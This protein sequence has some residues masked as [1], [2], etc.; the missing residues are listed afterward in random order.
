[1]K[2]TVLLC[3][4]KNTIEKSGAIN[5]TE[6]M[7]ICYIRMSRLGSSIVI[8]ENIIDRKED[9]IKTLTYVFYCLQLL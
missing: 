5:E 6:F 2:T 9:K 1:M 3:K 8:I 7:R 4:D